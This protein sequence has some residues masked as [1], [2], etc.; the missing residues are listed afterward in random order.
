[1]TPEQIA[2]VQVK[3]AR[4]EKLSEQLHTLFSSLHEPLAKVQSIATEVYQIRHDLQDKLAPK[5]RVGWYKVER[6]YTCNTQ[7]ATF[8]EVESET[9]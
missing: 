2:Q 3:V 9:I 4:L 5:D 1:M 7:P 8:D 6:G